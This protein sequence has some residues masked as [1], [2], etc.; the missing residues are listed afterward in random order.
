MSFRRATAEKFARRKL[1]MRKA[2]F[3]FLIFFLLTC[4][5]IPPE[6]S[7]YDDACA[8]TW[9][10]IMGILCGALLYAG[11]H[12]KSVYELNLPPY[13]ASCGIPLDAD[14]AYQNEV[15]VVL[16]I[17]NETRVCSEGVQGLTG[18]CTV[19]DLDD[20][21]DT[22]SVYHARYFIWMMCGTVVSLVFGILEYN[23]N[24]NWRKAFQCG[25]EGLLYAT[26]WFIFTFLP[27]VFS[28]QKSS[29]H[30]RYEDEDV[31]NASNV[32]AAFVEGIGSGDGSSGSY[33]DDDVIGMAAMMNCT[34]VP[35]C[36]KTNATAG[37]MLKSGAE[38]LGGLNIAAVVHLVIAS[39]FVV[40]SNRMWAYPERIW[41]ARGGFSRSHRRAHARTLQV[42]PFSLIVCV[43]T[44]FPSRRYTNTFS[45][46]AAHT[47]V[48]VTSRSRSP[49]G[50]LHFIDTCRPILQ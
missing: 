33:T 36:N 13:S 49:F 8:V 23:F 32:A 44:R 24:P 34:A 17:W 50:N 31:F 18:W 22:T 11:Y 16:D 25:D 5:M 6:A 9:C 2:G 30:L 43:L 38:C 39:T 10:W 21:S 37:W 40:R 47:C 26:I 27:G 7:D 12:R 35:C 42:T 3:V 29:S 48:L 45:V 4:C 28:I 46:S 20:V 14:M 19:D 1:R 41:N 15:D